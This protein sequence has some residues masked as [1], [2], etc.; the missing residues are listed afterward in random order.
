MLHL[1]PL[2]ELVDGYVEVVVAPERTRERSQD[3][4]PPDCEG[5]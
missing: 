1:L 2:G 3:V 5:P 4:Q